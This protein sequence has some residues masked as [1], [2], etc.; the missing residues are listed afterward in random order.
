SIQYSAANR[1]QPAASETR[2]QRKFQRAVTPSQT[3]LR[4]IAINDQIESS[5][6]HAHACTAPPRAFSEMVVACAL[7]MKRQML[8]RNVWTCARCSFSTRV[9]RVIPLTL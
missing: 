9:T 5:I 1:A 2:V 8:L 6:Y 3:P 7:S 4:A